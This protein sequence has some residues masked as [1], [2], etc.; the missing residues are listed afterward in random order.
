MRVLW[1]NFPLFSSIESLSKQKG[2][3]L[4]VDFDLF[5]FGRGFGLEYQ[6][7]ENLRCGNRSKRRIRRPIA[8]GF[9][10]ELVD[11]S[12]AASLELFGG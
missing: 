3:Q 11:K 4:D 8:L 10:C 2:L 9:F 5:G 12:R 1:L 6:T 7:L